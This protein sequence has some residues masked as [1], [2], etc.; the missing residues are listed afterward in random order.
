MAELYGRIPK[1]AQAYP[2]FLTGHAISI[3]GGKRE[4]AKSVMEHT[5]AHIKAGL[6]QVLQ[7]DP[8]VAENAFSPAFSRE[9]LA[10][11]VLEYLLV[12]LVQGQPDCGVL[13][14]MIRRGIYDPKG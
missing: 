7:R 9:D 12:A 4:Q 14:E 10:D 8:A 11:F 13:L 6:L 5:L 2:G 3:V 1:G